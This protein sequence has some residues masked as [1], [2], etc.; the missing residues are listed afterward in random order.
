MLSFKFSK[1][2][3]RCGACVAPELAYQGERL[4]RSTAL[5]EEEDFAV[6]RKPWQRA[7]NPARKFMPRRRGARRGFEPMRGVRYLFI[8]K[9]IL[10]DLKVAVCW[11]V[12][13]FARTSASSS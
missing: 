5:H 9:A 1:S 2:G 13:A 10:K 3:A 4:K 7:A 11:I 8:I 12:K 6:F